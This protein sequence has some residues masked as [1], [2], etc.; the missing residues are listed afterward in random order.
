MRKKNS[1]FC[2]AVMSIAGTATLLPSSSAH[3]AETYRSAWMTNWSGCECGGK[4]LNYTDDQ[5]NWFNSQ[6]NSHGYT[7]LS[8]YSNSSVWAGDVQEDS[9]GGN[10]KIY[11]D[12]AD[13]WAYSGHGSA[14]YVDGHQHYQVNFCKKGSAGNCLHDFTTSSVFGEQPAWPQASPSPGKNRWAVLATC[15]SVDQNVIDQWHPSLSIGSEY[16][17]GFRGVST[18]GET[19]DEV[20]GDFVRNAFTPHVPFKGA[21]FDAVDDWWVNDTGAV[22]TSHN[23]ATGVFWKLDHFNSRLWGRRPATWYGM[24]ATAHHEG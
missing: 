4:P 19:T 8:T 7:W 13:V 18:D 16:I 22:V 6:M 5:I 20:L 21:W 1:R 11:S 9:Y 12:D 14:P 24:Y 3:A 23:T 10:D 15:F 17:L 2:I